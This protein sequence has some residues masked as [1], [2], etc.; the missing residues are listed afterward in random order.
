MKIIHRWVNLALP[1]QENTTLQKRTEIHHSNF[2]GKRGSI[3]RPLINPKFTLQFK[4]W[5]WKLLTDYQANLGFWWK[6]TSAHFFSAPPSP[7]NHSSKQ[8]STTKAKYLAN[9][10]PVSTRLWV[11]ATAWQVMCRN[12]HLSYRGVTGRGGSSVRILPHFPFNQKKN[13]HLH[14]Y[15]NKNPWYK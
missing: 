3:L 12:R 5:K 15:S 8:L 4:R 9:F 14:Q 10:I 13:T 11:S 6:T 7:P 1:D 2:M